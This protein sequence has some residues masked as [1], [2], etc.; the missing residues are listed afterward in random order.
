MKTI[1]M[2][3]ENLLFLSKQTETGA[4]IR[5]LG[6]VPEHYLHGIVFQIGEM[7]I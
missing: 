6:S 4:S 1:F 2:V 5:A 3:K 7:R